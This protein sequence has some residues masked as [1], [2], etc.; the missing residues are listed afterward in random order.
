MSIEIRKLTPELAEDYVH[1]FDITP[2]DD[3]VDEHKCYCVC[4]SNEDYMNVD[5]STAEKRRQCAL[6]YVKGNNIQGYLA[7]SGDA[8]VGW[9]NA[10]TKSDCLKCASWQRFMFYVPL[11]EANEDIKVKS[12]FCF[13]IAPE[14]KRQGI[15]TLLLESVCKDAAQDGFD[16]V[17]VYPYKESSYQ[18]SNFGGHFEMYKKAGFYVL[19]ETEQGLIMR[20]KLK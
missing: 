1:F 6:Q 15:A 18:S 7:Y 20:K 4:W 13:T 9:C 12:I 3:N 5:L 10:N 19:K 8:V 16:F 11:E 14:K 2:H 17:E